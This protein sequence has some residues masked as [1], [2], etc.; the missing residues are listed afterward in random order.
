MLLLLWIGF[1]IVLVICVGFGLRLFCGIWFLAAGFWFCFLDVWCSLHLCSDF[2]FGFG[3][4]TLAGWVCGTALLVFDGLCI[5]FM[6]VFVSGLIMVLD[7]MVFWV[8]FIAGLW[9]LL[10]LYCRSLC[11]VC[12]C[13]LLVFVWV[14]W[15]L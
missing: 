5:A 6:V 12:D 10:L 7:L 11:W 14:A 13:V 2:G 9:L 4:V 1:Q 8:L 15:V 3:C